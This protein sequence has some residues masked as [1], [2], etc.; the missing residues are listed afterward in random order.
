MR[1]LAFL[2][3]LLFSTVLF[4]QSNI[5]YYTESS[6][7]SNKINHEYPF[8]ID[9]KRA[10]SSVIN[11]SKLFKK[12]NKPTVLLFWLTTCGPCRMELSA[13]SGKYSQWQKEAK[14][15]FFAISTDWQENSGQFVKRVQESKWQFEALHD[16]NREF[17]MVMPGE[18]NGLPQVFVLDKDGKIVYHKRKYIPGD[19]DQLFAEIKKLQ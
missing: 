1:L 13:I 11:S 6:R 19:E 2:S 14:F 16:F 9:L 10:D 7:P 3:A 5:R 15:N 12:N 8:D 17:R 18:L 4:G